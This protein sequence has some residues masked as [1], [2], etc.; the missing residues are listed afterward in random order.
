MPLRRVGSIPLSQRME[1]ARLRL[2]DQDHGNEELEDAYASG[3]QDAIDGSSGMTLQDAYVQ[4]FL[5]ALNEDQTG[6]V[7]EHRVGVDPVVL[8]TLQDIRGTLASRRPVIPFA[9]GAAAG[10]ALALLIYLVAR[11]R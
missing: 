5:S 11:S 1:R 10:L 9:T 4:G 2:I 7:V 8:K 3:F 6:L